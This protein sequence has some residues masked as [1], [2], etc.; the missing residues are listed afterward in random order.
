MFYN[1]GIRLRSYYHTRVFYT[2]GTSI[3]NAFITTIA[4]PRCVHSGCRDVAFKR[5]NNRSFEAAEILCIRYYLFSLLNS[6]RIII[7]NVFRTLIIIINR[8][9]LSA[10]PPN[11]GGPLERVSCDFSSVRFRVQIGRIVRAVRKT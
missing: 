3:N 9:V 6:F 11:G 8:I 5:N 4:K 7:I 1:A 10:M 2:S